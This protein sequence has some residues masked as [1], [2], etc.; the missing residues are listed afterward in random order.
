MATKKDKIK[1]KAKVK[2]ERKKGMKNEIKY[3]VKG[4]AKIAIILLAL[5]IALPGCQSADPASRSN[6]TSYGDISVV[7][8]SGVTLTVGDGLIAS[9]DGGGDTQ[10]NSPVQTTDIK[11]EVAA[12]FQGGSA[13][14]GGAKPSS[15]IVGEALSKLMGILGG[16]G[17]KL[18]VQEAE[19]IKDCADGNCSD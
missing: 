3:K 5:G 11:P 17:G 7:N 16:S 2:K 14:T 12:A 8:S 6:R 9:A 15:G 4:V 13:G 10:S 1:G 18:T 19:T